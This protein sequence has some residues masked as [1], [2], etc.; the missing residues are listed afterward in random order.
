MSQAS[1]CEQ[2][3]APPCKRLVTCQACDFRVDD[4]GVGYC[5]MFLERPARVPCAQW[6]GSCGGTGRQRARHSDAKLDAIKAI[7]A[8]I[9]RLHR[10]LCAQRARHAPQEPRG[11]PRGENVPKEPLGREESENGD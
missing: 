6:R 9:A 7:E 2:H 1:R 3:R 5:Y 8:G 10:R 11:A 4:S